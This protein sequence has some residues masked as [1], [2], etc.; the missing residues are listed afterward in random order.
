M[1]QTTSSLSERASPFARLAASN[2]AAHAAEQVSLVAVPMIAVTLLDAGGGV[3]GAMQML[4]TLPYLLFAI[5]FGLLIDRGRIRGIMAL[6]EL[7]RAVSLA[8]LLMTVISGHASIPLLALLGMTGSIGTVA[9]TVG[10]PTIVPRLVG[11]RSLSRANGNIELTRSLAFAGG[12]ALAGVLLGGIGAPAAFTVAV[13]LSLLALG[14]IWSL[15]P[16]A[17]TPASIARPLAQLAEGARFVW[18]H[19][20]LRPIVITAVMFNAAWFGL[21]G[22]YVAYAITQ[23]GMTSGQVGATLALYG[24]G[25]IVG[26]RLARPLE[27]RFSTGASIVIGPLCGA[28]G[29]LLILA[30]LIWPATILPSL[31]Y[32]LLGM[33]PVVW[34][35]TTTTLRQSVTPAPML[36]RV[37][38]LIV[39]STGGFRPIGAGLGATAYLMGGYELVLIAS[40]I[41]FLAQAAYIVRSAPARLR[42]DI[43]P[44]A[45]GLS[46]SRV[47][48]R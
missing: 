21:Q 4:N 29:S 41:G 42:S 24:V 14:L 28:M 3:T 13:M 9:F 36:G 2:L 1:E 43:Q 23:L 18:S 5:P 15:P 10:A 27:R 40:S 37:T 26:S 30:T 33:G 17:S 44:L 31:A 12:P 11:T 48:T 8:A 25:M 39:T 20:Y 22:V 34:T 47:P 32:L 7:I 6:G 35:I 19:A 46:T 38:A 45:P 16:V